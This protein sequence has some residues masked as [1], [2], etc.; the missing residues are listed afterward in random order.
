MK[1]GR[2]EDRQTV[3]SN[4]EKKKKKKP[5][6]I[7]GGNSQVLGLRCAPSMDSFVSS[8]QLLDGLK[9]ALYCI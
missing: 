2:K 6:G 7:Q 1:K 9:T 8:S 4:K 5:F 3:I